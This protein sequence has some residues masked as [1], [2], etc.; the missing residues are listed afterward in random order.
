MYRMVLE[1]L[2]LQPHEAVFVGND[3]FR[4]IFGA[5]AAGMK[6]VFFHSNQ[7]E[8]KFSG[9]EPDYIIYHFSELP[10]AIKFLSE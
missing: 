1:K 8:Q 3:M 9:A 4:D 2:N 10:R 6:T 7:G 5:H